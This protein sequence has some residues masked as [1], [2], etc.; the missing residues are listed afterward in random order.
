MLT[1]SGLGDKDHLTDHTSPVIVDHWLASPFDTP[2]HNSP[3]SSF[4]STMYPPAPTSIP[5]PTPN[6][7]PNVPLYATSTAATSTTTLSASSASEH[8]IQSLPV[9][10]F[11]C[12]WPPYTPTT[13][14]SSSSNGLSDTLADELADISLRIRRAARAMPPTLLAAVAES[15]LPLTWPALD[16]ALEATCSLINLVDRYAAT[17]GS[18]ASPASSVPPTPSPTSSPVCSPTRTVHDAMDTSLLLGIMAC[19]QTVLGVFGALCNVLNSN[20]QRLQQ[21]QQTAATTYSMSPVSSSL[22]QVIMTANLIDHLLGQLDRAV[23]ALGNG[24]GQI[25][26]G[27]E[28]L[29][30]GAPSSPPLSE[31]SGDE[32]DSGAESGFENMKHHQRQGSFTVMTPTMTGLVLTQ[33]EQ[34]QAR[35]RGQTIM[36]KRSLSQLNVL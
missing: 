34:R 5:Q 31:V 33:A 18:L 35:V 25:H 2:D 13:N 23:G 12:Q 10:D 3:G 17:R 21:Q 24:V 19:H 4:S 28:C 6:P 7:V 15:S 9:S 22:S 1:S 14:T 27:L 36:V 20:I 32:F 8:A 16:N 11:G 30:G 29:P 26:P